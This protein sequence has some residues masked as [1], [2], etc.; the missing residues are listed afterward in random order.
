MISIG[1]SRRSSST[2][3]VGGGALRARRSS[4]V[5]CG[6]A[7]RAIAT[8][9]RTRPTLGCCSSITVRVKQVRS[10]KRG[11]ASPTIVPP[12]LHSYSD[13]P[14]V[15]RLERAVQGICAE[16]GGARGQ[17]AADGQLRAHQHRP[18]FWSRP[19]LP[20]L[21]SL[22]PECILHGVHSARHHS[23]HA[24]L[25]WWHAGERAACLPRRAPCNACKPTCALSG[26]RSIAGGGLPRR[27]SA[28]RRADV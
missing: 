4:P 1:G 24:E 8:W 14:A 22:P 27:P 7:R 19:A 28:L 21:R 16:L 10:G 3:F 25:G 13:C 20:H 5:R 12:S 17:V 2:R 9:S 26:G 23:G 6:S 15:R 11:Q 18:K